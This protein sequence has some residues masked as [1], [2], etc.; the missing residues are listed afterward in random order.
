MQLS[1]ASLLP[2]NATF[3]GL[4]VALLLAAAAAAAF[5]HLS[6]DAVRTHRARQI[7]LAGARGALQ[8][9]VVS[10]VIVWVVRSLA[11]TA[12]FLTLM[13]LVAVRTAGRRITRDGT[14]WT[15]AL[16]LA[17]GVLPVMV[18]LLATGLIPLDGIVLIPI[19]GILTGGALSA[20]VLA[21]R[22]ALDE[23][24]LRH[25]EVESGLALGLTERDA[26]LEIARP[27]AS[28]A[29]IPGLDQTRTVGLVT[30][31][32][33]F[34]GMLLGGADPLAAGAV[35]LFVLVALMAVQAVA[36]ALTIELV[37][38]GRLHAS[39]HTSDRP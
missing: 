5:F 29:L 38:R 3:A 32:G 15:T 18:A 11:A 10:V 7:L 6:P 16:P 39:T 21:G 12:A 1:A 36:V 9:A 33:A 8:L 20:T 4:L 23:L 2:V 37:A 27:A 17:A 35:Q 26:R 13:L 24:R 31:P 28:E 14:W 30:L 34:V 25:G 19:T 22:R